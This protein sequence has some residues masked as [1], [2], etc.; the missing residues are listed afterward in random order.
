MYG[1]V[2]PT[3]GFNL[4]TKLLAGETL[5]ITRVMVGSGRLDDS[6]D[7]STI[8]ELVQPVAAATFTIPNVNN[9]IASFVVE[10]RSDMNGGLDAGFWLNEFGVFAL[11]PDIGEVLLYYGALGDFPQFVSPFQG[12][13]IDI[14]RFPVAIILSKDVSISIDYP[15]IAFMTAEDVAEYFIYTALPIALN[16]AAALIA[17]HNTAPDAHP[18]IWARLYELDGRMGRLE[19]MLISNITGNPFLVTFA[20]LSG[21]VVT[22]VW[23]QPQ[24]RIEF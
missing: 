2:I 8:T 14:L 12:G 5:Q 21:V 10:Y 15:P 20:D 11:D 1:F 13:S 3:L 22:G 23:N 4:L 19:E 16:E 7:P 17:V 6:I 24:Q 18:D 9:N